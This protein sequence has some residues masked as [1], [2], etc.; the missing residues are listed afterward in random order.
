MQGMKEKVK[1]MASAAKEKVK[2][3][4]AN[5][6]GKAEQATA[7][8]HTEREMA[9]EKEKA[10]EDE[11]KAELHGEKAQHRA[12]TAEHQH[13]LGRVPLTGPHHHRPV[14]TTGGVVDPTY[15]T[16]GTRPATEKYF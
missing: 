10:R 13:G 14:G 3:G 4:T 7:R 12:E 1:D 16:S 11:A 15:P 9:K 6:Q 5:V 8:T 2:E